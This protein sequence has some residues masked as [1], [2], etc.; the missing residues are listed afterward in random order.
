MTELKCMYQKCIHHNFL[1]CTCQLESVR[2]EDIESG[3][4]YETI[5]EQA[6]YQT[7]YWIH[8]KDKRTGANFKRKKKGKRI[9][10]DGV[11]LYTDEKIPPEAEW[12]NPQWDIRCTEEK[13]GMI[14]PLHS[15]YIP[16]H[17]KKIDEYIKNAVPFSEL[18][19]RAEEDD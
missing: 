11:V 7:E 19:E 18:E 4:C 1:E 6:E 8:C 12:K 15:L 5:T 16:E 2:V 14:V 10:V 13:T 3:E 9:E 17:R